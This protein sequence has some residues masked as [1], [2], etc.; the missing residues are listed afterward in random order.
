MGR[1]F[2][3]DGVRGIAN[4]E[5]T[6]ELAFKLGQAGAKVLTKHTN[7]AHPKILVGKDTRIS[8]DMLEASLVAGF[9]SVGAVSV[10]VGQIPT[11]A[12]AYLVRKYKADAGVVISA[13]HNSVE[14]NGIKFFSN[15]GYKLS[16]DLENEIEE[17]ILGGK[18]LGEL[19]DG[20]D[21][22]R[23][24]VHETGMRDYTDFAKSCIDVRLDGLK[25]ALDCANGAA[26][27]CAKLA[28]KELGAETLLINNVPDG[29][30]INKNCGSTHIEGLQKFVADNKCDMGFA[31]DGDADR[32]LAVDENGNLVDG[33]KIMVICAKGLKDEGKLKNNT[34][35]A[36]VMSNLGFFKALD[37]I[38][39]NYEQTT[40]GDRY[41]L[42]N[43]LENGHI[44]GGEQSGHVILLEN[45][46]TGDGLVTA[47][48][49]ASTAAK[50]K[51][52]L[53]ELAGVV[54]VLPQV[55]VNV[56]VK[57]EHKNTYSSDSV[58]K[59]EI[60][61]LEKKFDGNG[62][63]LIRPSGTEPLIRVMLEGENYD[64]I[65]KEAEAL[66]D[67]IRERLS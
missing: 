43:M 13:S 63:V 36:T 55:L 17:Y 2:G 34:V 33:D 67:V 45:N 4:K 53:S 59:G 25:I 5:L 6:C 12:V 48:T 54:T 42:Q 7:N 16:D 37:K 27:E 31:F 29:T 19:P 49:V 8:G 47:L 11:P 15:E 50:L 3:T 26:F 21:I 1:L 39:I 40:V 20:C 41:V 51:K 23:K 66:A 61:K 62:R 57:N 64:E 32:C 28:F 60:E 46:T 9:C 35:V 56:T 30:N 65:K 52:K 22:G 44:I 10:C 14:Y 58:I 38:G 24:R 18:D